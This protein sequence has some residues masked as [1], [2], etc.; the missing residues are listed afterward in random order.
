M[1]LENK[2]QRIFSQRAVTFHKPHE[3]SHW[4]EKGFALRRKKIGKRIR[5]LYRRGE[6]VLDLGSG[7]GHYA[8]FF[9]APVLLDYS[10]PVLKKAPDGCGGLRLCADFSALPFRERVF[11]GVLSVGLLQCRRL[12]EADLAG[13]SRVLKPG[14]WFVVETLNCEWKGLLAEMPRAERDRLAD[15]V[16]GKGDSPCY[17]VHNDFVLYHPDKLKAWF[18]RAGL[19]VT[20]VEY[21][22]SLCPP[23]IRLAARVLSDLGARGL[24]ERELHRSFVLSGRKA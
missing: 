6:G 12:K 9:Q 7:P 2:W 10:L 15:F 13:L 22:Y 5:S 14:G 3:I 11:D 4:T 16:A 8:S 19:L 17:F 1:E 20:D 23:P 18:R 21:V 24:S